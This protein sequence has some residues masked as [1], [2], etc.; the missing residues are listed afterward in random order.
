VFFYIFDIAV[1]LSRDDYLTISLLFFFCRG[2]SHLSRGR[3][4]ILYTS[5]PPGMTFGWPGIYND[6][7]IQRNVVNFLLAS[8]GED[9]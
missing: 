8:L 6:K 4:H 5:L 9:V 1:D 2:L 3:E 7:N